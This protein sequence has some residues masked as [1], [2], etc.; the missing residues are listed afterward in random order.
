M[1]LAKHLVIWKIVAVSAAAAPDPAAQGSGGG[2]MSIMP[3]LVAI[4]A[5]MYFLMIRPQQKREKERRNMLG[6]LS[7]GDSVV[8]NGGVC[9]S[10][11]GLSD[12]HVVL[13]VD[14]DVTIE[15]VRSAISQVSATRG[16]AK[17]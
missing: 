4:F 11:V 8:T 16:D 17:S 10:I 15:F 13:R 6:A 3:M 12:S 5:I 1:N 14:D 7:K 9:G 2:F